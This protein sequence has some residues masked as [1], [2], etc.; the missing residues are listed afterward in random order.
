MPPDTV[1]GASSRDSGP[2]PVAAPPVPQAGAPPI[3]FSWEQLMHK[4]FASSPPCLLPSGAS[5][6]RLLYNGN[7]TTLGCGVC[8]PNVS[9]FKKP[10]AFMTGTYTVKLSIDGKTPYFYGRTATTH[11]ESDQHLDSVQALIVLPDPPAGAA[12]SS[13]A[14]PT[15]VPAAQSSTAIPPVV[16]SPVP[17]I[18]KRHLVNSPSQRKRNLLRSMSGGPSPASSPAVAGPSP[19]MI[20]P[21]AA[22][23]SH[24]S[25]AGSPSASEGQGTPQA[26]ARAKK[27][28][29]LL[30]H[31]RSVYMVVNNGW[32]ASVYVQHMMCS[33]MNGSDYL[34]G[35]DQD[36]FFR[37]A[38]Q[39]IHQT[40]SAGLSEDAAKSPVYS[41]SIDERGLFVNVIIGFYSMGKVRPIA[42]FAGYR[43]VPDA[44]ARGLLAVIKKVFLDLGLDIKRLSS[45]TADGAST[46]GTRAAMFSGLWNWRP[47]P[48]HPNKIN[49]AR[50][51]ERHAQM[52]AIITDHPPWG[53]NPRPQG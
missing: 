5:W 46:M 20:S 42:A 53:S 35:H 10:T 34:Q 2:P 22:A 51:P 38:A 25:L 1:G 27:F 9:A 43:E 29:L 16:V 13:P 26:Q 48:R 52:N 40:V 45:F 39:E 24:G 3:A 30:N 23:G 17:R 28:R 21:S 6:L 36:D 37:S 8:M 49:L 14:T 31:M 15:G 41:L 4:K 18:A 44:T 32:S 7:K 47:G 33:R 19:G 11:A 50:I 12:A